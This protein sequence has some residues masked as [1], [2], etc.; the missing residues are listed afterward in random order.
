MIITRFVQHD[1]NWRADMSLQLVTCVFNR[2]ASD[3]NDGE[4]SCFA[5]PY[6]T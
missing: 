6:V 3:S 2:N 1:D 5:V 4:T